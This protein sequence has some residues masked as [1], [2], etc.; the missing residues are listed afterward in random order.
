MPHQQTPAK[1]LYLQRCGRLRTHMNDLH[2]MRYAVT[3]PPPTPH[4]GRAPVIKHMV[5]LELGDADG[6]AWRSNAQRKKLSANT[7][8]ND[9]CAL[10][11]LREGG[12]LRSSAQYANL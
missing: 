9:L 5:T 2:A 10:C 11:Q 8:G 12:R 1:K 6:V 3:P 7:G 4:S